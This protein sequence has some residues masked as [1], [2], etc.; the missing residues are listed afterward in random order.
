MPCKPRTGPN[1]S[2]PRPAP[3]PSPQAKPHVDERSAVFGRFSSVAMVSSYAGFRCS[4]TVAAITSLVSMGRSPAVGVRR[5][6][7]VLVWGDGRHRV[8]RW[9][10][11]GAGSV[12]LLASWSGGG[13]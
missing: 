5:G 13:R 9:E 8:G 11:A 3:S 7:A 2:P 10:G 1:G 4:P 6:V 12:D